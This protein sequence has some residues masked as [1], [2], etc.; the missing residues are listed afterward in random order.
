MYGLGI[1]RIVFITLRESSSLNWHRGDPE[2]GGLPSDRPASNSRGAEGFDG[3]GETC[4][5]ESSHVGTVVC[6]HDV[7]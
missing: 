5:S 6:R 4:Q 1:T 3:H 2:Q 7:S